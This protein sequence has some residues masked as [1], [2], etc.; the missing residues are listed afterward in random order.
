MLESFFA[1]VTNF[2]SAFSF[3]GFGVCVGSAL[4]FGVG[5]GVDLGELF[6]V[7]EALGFGAMVGVGVGDGIWISLFAAAVEV[8]IG[9]G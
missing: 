7:G 3:G 2:F 8:G 6:G 4:F 1:G 5:F 9:S